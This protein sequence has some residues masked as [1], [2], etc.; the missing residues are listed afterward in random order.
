MKRLL[1][2]LLLAWLSISFYSGIWLF[3]SGFLLMRIELG[4]Q[5]Q[6][7]SPPSAAPH[8]QD[9]RC[10]FPQRFDKAV[11]VI[12]DALKYDFAKYNPENDNP[13]PYE[14]KLG[15][16]HRLCSAQPRH[17]RLYP[18]RADPP[19][20][21]MQRIKGFTT[22]SLPTFVDLGSNF[23]SY[24]IQED[25]L[26][27]Q[28]VS[29]GK[30]VVFMGDDTWD[31]LFPK[32][33]YKSYFFP[34]FNVKD[35]H[36][37][38]DGI[39]QHLYPTVDGGDWDVIIAHFLG[40]DH[41]G[42][43]HGPDHPETAKKLMQMN[44][45]IASLIEHLDDKTLLVV[46]G[47][48]GMTDTGDHGGD[49]EKEVTAALFLY[50]KAPL[51]AEQLKT[52]AP[53]VPQVNLVP[54][55][56]LL[57]GL[58]IPY[59]NLGGVID[60]LFG[61]PEDKVSAL[62]SKTTAYH[63]NV[64]QVA[65]YLDSYS[66]AAGDLP[67]EKLRALADLFTSL[68]SEYEQLM[69]QRDQLSEEELEIHLQR[70]LQRQQ[71]YLDQARHVCM[72]SWAR[73]HPM[74]MLMGCIILLT[75]CFFCYI[76]AEAGSVLSLPYKNLLGYP[77]LF[78]ISVTSALG[79]AV[80]TS[81]LALDLVTVC[82]AATLIFQI[83]FYF[84]FQAKKSSPSRRQTHPVYLLLSGPCVVLLFRCCSLFSDS[85]V[86]AEGSV[87]P[88]LLTSLLTV[89]VVKLHWDGK[90]L[91]PTFTPLGSESL[92]PSLT[93]AYR[94]DGSRL[95]WLLAA[96][97]I[98]VRLSG[99]FHN[100][101][102]ETPDCQPS[103]FLS[104]LS[105]IRDPDIKN[106]SYVFC[107]VFLGFMVFLVRKWLQHYGNLN[108]ASPLVLYVRWGFPLI[109]LGIACYW[110]VSSGTE[111]SLAKL[112]ELTHLALVA[113]PRAI[114]AMAGL[115]LLLI[116]WNPITV[117]MKSRVSD[118]DNTVTTYRGAPSSEA[119]L[120]HV[121]PQIYRKM[122]RTLKS[123][124]QHGGEGEDGKKGVSV[125][126]YGL[127]S[128]Y[129]AAMVITL[130]ILTLVLIL[131]HSERMTPA[132]LLLLLEAVIILHIH[133]HVTNLYSE[134]VE[135]FSVPWYSV[136]AWSLAA[137]QN[138]YST[139]HQPVFPA[140]HW[141]SAFVGFQEGHTNNI[142][143]ALLVAANTFSANI[144]FS[145]GSCLLLLWPFLCEAPTGRRR[146]GKKEKEG[147]T[148]DEETPM[149]EM[150]IREDPDRFSVALLQLGTKYLFIQGVQL[151]SCVCAAMIL[152][153]HLMVWKIFAPKFLFEALGFA[154]SSLFLLL[155]IA[156]VLR[157]DCAVSNWFRNL[158]LQ[159]NR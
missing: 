9:A 123:R 41:C 88:F 61:W 27:H 130:S 153:R 154:V 159:Q 46:A 30:R 156:L 29:N 8:L 126:A 127:G 6:C 133:G 141:N 47:D 115:G 102:E 7:S 106:V 33:F 68:T 149:M 56:S 77:L 32:K 104:P 53:A 128:V 111:D 73:F 139:G 86:V 28:M 45:V 148:E 74:H 54:S 90:L 36:T 67:A 84:N 142:V 70:I 143:P 12:I 2:M 75:S 35:L 116:L 14:N 37:V 55:L 121:I 57:L 135:L 145:A 79:L 108:I 25:N 21:T 129:S 93:P 69:S 38:D 18:F 50:S 71:S 62:L 24:A 119:E 19:T 15:E 78:T 97:G 66:R 103:S 120:Q 22:G 60:D 155:G 101:R 65:R 87:A 81:G 124:L 64:Q 89:T 63:I 39:L 82:A 150:R 92:K 11:I 131:L 100:C 85:Y 98:C 152:R 91:L 110:A 80:W 122:Q 48:H 52:E 34:S 157:V 51:F 23:A 10:W 95:M 147:G 138:F 42:H 117:F 76:I 140:I 158:T 5:S 107:V 83:S 17:A 112:K 1:L 31:G 26:I 137:T 13:K 99:F 58:P 20:T 134:G 44:Q 132:F 144:L 40:V 109:V 72:E 49:S 146:K 114:Y 113:C 4:N 151:L 94:R 3:M 136:L 43:K 16:I 59:S 125:E 118:P 105:S 96:L